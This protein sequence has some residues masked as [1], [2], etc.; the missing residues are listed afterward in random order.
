MI[1]CN[2]HAR[3]PMARLDFRRTRSSGRLI[4]SSVRFTLALQIAAVGTMSTM[5]AAENYL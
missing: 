3:S 5:R 4:V 1:S 2:Y